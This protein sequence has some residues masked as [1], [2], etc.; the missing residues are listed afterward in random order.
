[1]DLPPARQ[2]DTVN[3]VGI[4]LGRFALDRGD[5]N[6]RPAN[7]RPG[8]PNHVEETRTTL[9]RP[10]QETRTKLRRPEP[11]WLGSGDPNHVRPEEEETRTTLAARVVVQR[12]GPRSRPEPC[13]P[14]GLS[15]SGRGRART[16]HP[17]VRLAGLAAVLRASA[18]SGPVRS[19]TRAARGNTFRI[20][21]RGRTAGRTSARSVTTQKRS[22]AAGY[23]GAIA[24]AAPPATAAP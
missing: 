20:D 18:G 14:P 6:R 7:R 22:Q 8:D 23:P 15:A 3:G 24:R 13:S 4:V 17:A 9:R 2:E 10:E 5:P 1:V 11:R 21:A 19:R 12:V 16:D